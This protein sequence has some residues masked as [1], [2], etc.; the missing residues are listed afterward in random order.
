[1]IDLVEGAPGEHVAALLAHELDVSFQLSSVEHQGLDAERMWI[2]RVF[3][4]M[5]SA[6][7]P[8]C[9]AQCRIAVT[10]SPV[11]LHS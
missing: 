7:P 1:M 2:D 9:G 10:C 8:A 11:F 4:A 3:A 5:P 6:A